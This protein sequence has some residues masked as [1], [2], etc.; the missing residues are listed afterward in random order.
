MQVTEFI[1]TV[2]LVVVGAFA[3]YALD[4]GNKCLARDLTV[5]SVGLIIAYC[6]FSSSGWAWI[7]LRLLVIAITAFMAGIPSH[8][9]SGVECH[10]SED[11]MSLIEPI[12][13]HDDG[14]KIFSVLILLAFLG[15]TYCKGAPF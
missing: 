10:C 3:F 1:L 8:E 6:I 4:K 13:N 15:C 14:E 7:G 12:S 9:A 11:P 5:F 2:L